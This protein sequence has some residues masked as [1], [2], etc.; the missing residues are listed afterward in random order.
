MDEETRP[1]TKINNFI[2]DFLEEHDMSR[3]FDMTESKHL[4]VLLKTLQKVQS[5]K[6]EQE[7]PESGALKAEEKN[8]L[9]VLAEVDNK[10]K[11]EEFVNQALSLEK[12]DK[13]YQVGQDIIEILG[14]LEEEEGEEQEEEQR[15]QS[16]SFEDQSDE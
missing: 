1:P 8:W 14:E 13:N 5:L 9:E 12:K 4:K 16:D 15:E 2:E 7:R 10:F 6:L 3:S 11:V